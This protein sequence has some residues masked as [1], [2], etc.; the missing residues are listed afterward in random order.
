MFEGGRGRAEP[1]FEARG[2]VDA[3]RLPPD[4]PV[5]VSAP[6]RPEMVH[7]LRAV[8][9]S[10]AARLDF[11]YDDIDDLRIS[12]DEACAQLLAIGRDGDT[13]TLRLSTTD[14]GIEALV[15]LD[16]PIEGAWPPP[17]LEESLAWR[18]LT[19]LSDEVSFGSLPTGPG[20][21]IVKVPSGSGEP[22]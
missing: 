4:S 13:F 3:M 1:L 22:R 11:P 20:I 18:V 16:A 12:I 6:A 19:G 17:D 7:V 15:S 14:R 5:V 21:R 2:R 8:A 9:S 10:V